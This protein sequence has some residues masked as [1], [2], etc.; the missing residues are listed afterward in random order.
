MSDLVIQIART[1]AEFDRKDWDVI[2]LGQQMP[3]VA[4]ALLVA[5]VVR[6]HPTEEGYESR[7]GSKIEGL[8]GISV[9]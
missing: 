2:S 3:Y 9:V 7:S 5:H 6:E 8:G 4:R 1:L